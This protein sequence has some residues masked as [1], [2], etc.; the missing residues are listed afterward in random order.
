MTFVLSALP[1]GGA[2][3]LDQQGASHYP[4]S[5]PWLVD[6]VHRIAQSVLAIRRAGPGCPHEVQ[7]LLFPSFVSPWAEPHTSSLLPS[8]TRAAKAAMMGRW[9]SRYPTIRDRRSLLS[10]HF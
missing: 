7:A 9:V 10:P 8:I 1:G 2:E 4:R 5:L 3:A 6:Q